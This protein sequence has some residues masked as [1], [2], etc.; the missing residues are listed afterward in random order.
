[1]RRSIRSIFVSAAL[2]LAL[3]PAAVSAQMEFEGAV[4]MNMNLG[5]AMSVDVLTLSKGNRVRQ[6]MAMMGQNLVSIIDASAGMGLLLMPATQSYVKL[7]FKALAAQAGPQS[8]PTITPTGTSETIVGHKC[9]NYTVTIPHGTIE[10]CVAQDLGFYMGSLNAQTQGMGNASM[11]AHADVF[12]QT[13]KDGFFPLKMVATS[14]STAITMTVTNIEQKPISD[15]QFKLDVP[16]GYTEMKLST[17]GPGG[18]AQ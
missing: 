8:T 13:F 4:T 17:R 16:A 11:Q 1:M 6:E 5:G 10:M 15:D 7:D 9:D 18:G 2:F 3:A 12:R 14:Q